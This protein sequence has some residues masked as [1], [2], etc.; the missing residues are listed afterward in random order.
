VVDPWG[1]RG[2]QSP[3]VVEPINDVKTPRGLRAVSVGGGR[4]ELSWI[5][6][7]FTEY[8]FKIERSLDGVNWTQIGIAARDAA[9]YSDFLPGGLR[10]LYRVR[11]FGFSGDT[12]Y[13]NIAAATAPRSPLAPGNRPVASSPRPIATIM[14][15]AGGGGLVVTRPMVG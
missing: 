7:S 11:A 4:I 14:P 3:P 12:G 9:T 2:E 10:A 1:D 13:S 5:D 6:E 8:G 15:I